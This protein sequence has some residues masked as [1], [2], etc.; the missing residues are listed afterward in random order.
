MIS[1]IGLQETFFGQN[2]KEIL[3]QACL[4]LLLKKEFQLTRRI[5]TYLFSSPDAEGHYAISEETDPVI[6]IIE[7]ALVRVLFE[8]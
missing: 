8:D 2:E 6:R 4:H 3:V 7:K 1:Y 5:Y